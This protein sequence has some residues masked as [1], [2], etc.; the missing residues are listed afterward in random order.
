MSMYLI[1][2]KLEERTEEYVIYSYGY[3]ETVLDGRFKISLKDPMNSEILISTSDERVSHSGAMKALCKLI[4]L[5]QNEEIKEQ[6][7]YIA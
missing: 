1:E 2:M 5:I 6:E 3:P 4:R 7:F